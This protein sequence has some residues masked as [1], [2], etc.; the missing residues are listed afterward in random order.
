M[1]LRRC[2]HSSCR[3]VCGS[4]VRTCVPACLCACVH[5]GCACARMYKLICKV[6]VRAYVLA[7]RVCMISC[8]RAHTPKHMRAHT[9][10]LMRVHTHVCMAQAAIYARACAHIPLRTTARVRACCTFCTFLLVRV[11][12]Y[13][14]HAQN[15]KLA[16]AS[17]MYACH[18]LC[19]HTRNAPHMHAHT[20]T[21]CAHVCVCVCV[22][23]TRTHGCGYMHRM[24]MHRQGEEGAESPWAII[25]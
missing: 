22:H 16:H 2:L 21:M 14:R 5:R 11:F 3:L 15:K 17:R 12:D 19:M 18:R 24:C 20:R 10:K 7:Q 9:R 25:V 4:P 6:P 23:C 13:A 8:V 1:A